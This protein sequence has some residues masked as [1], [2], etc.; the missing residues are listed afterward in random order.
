MLE[1]IAFLIGIIPSITIHEYGH[2]RAAFAVGDDTAARAG[3]MTLNPVPHIDPFM[4]VLLPLLLVVSGSP[5]VFGAARPVP[6]NPSR[7]THLRQGTILVSAAGAL[8]NIALAATLGIL[9]RVIPTAGP[10]VSRLIVLNVVLAVF[11]L[12]PIPPLDGWHVLEGLLPRR[13]GYQMQEMERYGFLVLFIV[14][15]FFSDVLWTVIGPVI[16]SIVGV[17]VP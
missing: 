4:T 12:L 7:F 13:Y 6:V 15:I 11:N 1:F 14:L 9:M 5:I 16:R 10:Y 8:S 3:R 17:M 2:A